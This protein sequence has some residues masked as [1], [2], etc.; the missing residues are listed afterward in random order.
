MPTNVETGLTP[1]G[2]G[3]V[4]TWS[5]EEVGEEAAALEAHF[6]KH[7]REGPGPVS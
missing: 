7:L 5:R 1:L 3:T 4:F 2:D 6:A